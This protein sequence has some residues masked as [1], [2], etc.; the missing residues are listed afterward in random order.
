MDVI[1]LLSLLMIKHAFA[2]M[3]LQTFHSGV[4]KS[5]YF[6][7]GQRHYIE[8]GVLTFLVVLLFAPIQIALAVAFLDYVLHWQIDFIKSFVVKKFNIDRNSGLFWRIQSIDQLCHYMTYS[9]IVYLLYINQ[10]VTLLQQ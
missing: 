10:Y 2:D 5:N 9:L 7:N 6:G 1:L 8:H 4:N 3:F